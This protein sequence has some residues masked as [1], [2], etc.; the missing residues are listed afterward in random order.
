[1]EQNEIEKGNKGTA[2]CWNCEKLFIAYD[3]Q[4]GDESVIEDQFCCSFCRSEW[5]S[6][7]RYEFL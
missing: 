4:Q 6:D 5:M 1:M 7:N 3:T 2:A